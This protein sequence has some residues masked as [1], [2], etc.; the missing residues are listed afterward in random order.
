MCKDPS[1]STPTSTI[2]AHRVGTGERNAMWLLLALCYL[3]AFAP[4][5]GLP[6]LLALLVGWLP[7]AFAGWHLARW[8]GWRTALL[9]FAII[10]AV[11]FTFEALGV[12]TGLVFGDY[13]YP[14]GP[15]GPL[16]LGVPPL[17]QLQYFAMGYASL[18]VARAVSGT[19]RAP[20]RGWTLLGASVM[21]A[22]A[23]TALDLASDPMQSTQLGDWI[24][25]DG[26]A[27]FGV[28]IHNFIG[29]FVATG[30]F[31]VLVN[32]VLL[33]PAAVQRITEQRP[34]WF[35]LQG[36][37]LYGTFPFAI[38]V[39]PLLTERTDIVLAMA[40]VATFAVLPILLAAILSLG[41]AR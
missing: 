24:W 31:F 18:Q 38:I 41:R 37:L 21:G 4:Q 30:T 8:S 13:Y 1:M 35:Y 12:A 27:Y 20:A 17:I 39:R 25:R 11:S 36:V 3:T 29:W 15:L 6:G 14:D 34:A 22:F 28:P 7:V 33:R 23:M 16:V 40:G 32:L 26:G 10:A 5:E 9:V 19:L 2:E